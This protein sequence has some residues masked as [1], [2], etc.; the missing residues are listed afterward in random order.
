MTSIGANRF[1]DLM[2]CNATKWK[3]TLVQ[4]PHT[5]QLPLLAP[6]DDTV[7]QRVAN[8]KALARATLTQGPMRAQP[9]PPRSGIR[10]SDCWISDILSFAPGQYDNSTIHSLHTSMSPI[11]ESIG[12]YNSASTFQLA[13][14][15]SSMRQICTRSNLHHPVEHTTTQSRV[16]AHSTNSY[17]YRQE[18]RHRDRQCRFTQYSECH[19]RFRITNAGA[20][21]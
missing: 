7:T 17:G 1:L 10:K 12:I 4:Q 21:Y 16:T 14:Q 13:L 18:A 11:M 19:R 5:T 20:R 2:A 9:H 6:V 8:F 15:V 3:K